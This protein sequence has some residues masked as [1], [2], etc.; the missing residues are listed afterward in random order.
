MFF[1]LCFSDVPQVCEH[2][3]MLLMFL[4]AIEA[5]SCPIGPSMLWTGQAL[6][7]GGQGV[8]FPNGVRSDGSSTTPLKTA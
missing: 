8:A 5:R 7:D 2:M 3:H 4:G 1:C 6:N